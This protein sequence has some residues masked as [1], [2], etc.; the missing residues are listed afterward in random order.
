MVERVTRGQFLATTSGVIA[1]ILI[2]GPAYAGDMAVGLELKPEVVLLKQGDLRFPVSLVCPKFTVDGTEV[3]GKGPPVGK[4]GRMESGQVLEFPC[5]PIVLGD[6]SR[7][8]VKLCVEWSAYELVLRKW[9]AYRLDGASV[10]KL[11]SEVV[12]EDLNTKAAGPRLLPEQPVN[13]DGIQSRPVFLE[14]FFAGIEYPVA[15]CRAE[16]GRVIL[17]HRPGLRMQPG[18]WYQ[19]RKAVYGITPAGGEK[20]GFKR[21]IEAHRPMPKGS[22]HFMYNPYWS[23]PTTPSQ[24]QILEIMGI[25]SEKLYK[26]YGVAFDSCG[27][28]VFTTDTKSIW[29]VDRKRFPR[30]LADLQQACS[31]IGSHLDIFLSPCSGYPPALDPE[32][33]KEQ[34]YETCDRGAMRTLCLAGKRYQSQTKKAIVDT[35]VRYN[36]NHVFLDGYTFDCPASDHGHEPGALSMEPVADGLIDILTALRKAAPDVWLAATCFTWNASPWWCFHVNS[37]IGAY[38]DDAPYGRV[39]SPVYRESYT[40]ARDHFNLQGAYWL[41]APIAATESFGIIHQSDYPFLNDAVTDILRGNMEQHC[42]I[43][44]AYMSDIRW[45]Q[46]ASLMKWARRNVGILRNTEPLLPVSW[47]NGKCPQVTNDA[48][49]PREP[50]GYAHWG[51][52]RSLLVLRNPWIEPQTY[53]VKLP[54]DPDQASETARFSAVS[55]YPESRVYGKDLKPG[56][57]LDVRLAPYETVVLSF[58]KG[59]AP[60]DRPPVSQAICRQLNVKVL[61]SEVSLEKFAGNVDVLGGDSTCLVGNAEAGMRVDLDAEVNADAPESDVLIL[62]EEKEAP[63]DPICQLRVNGKEVPLSSGGSETGWA[64][65]MLPKPER[66]LFLSSPLPEGKSLISLNLLTRGGNPVVSAW[67]WAKK[68]GAVGGADY[69]NALPQ[70]EVISLDGVNLLKPLDA[71]A[72]SKITKT[73]ARPVERIDGVFLDAMDPSRVRATSGGLGKNACLSQAPIVIAGRRYLRGLGVNAP[74]RIAVSLDGNYRRFQ[75]WVGLDTAVVANYMDRSAVTFEVWVDG[76][77]RW[78]SGVVRDTDPAEP[79]KL[80]DIDVAGAKV[81]ELAVVAQEPHG[82]LAQNLVDWAEA[83]LLK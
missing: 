46:L 63:V 14:G 57:T 40:S 38:G 79:V 3:G 35:V 20:K 50:Y 1:T 51:D 47:Q 74:S 6:S 48:R 10:P 4:V 54:V 21:Y 66:W 25:L 71:K 15:Q 16:N 32:W 83:R 19:T 36:A 68:A 9:A 39:P 33:A 45:S 82:H 23:T 52:D 44:P 59:K 11:L 80:V 26:P 55:I 7:L 31:S 72:A 13:A 69:P 64:A 30:G 77:K 24:D 41:T 34:G 49:M 27:L 58:D 29:E 60:S 17:S 61:K 62:L 53:T 56:D 81:L 65:S 18:T 12:L 37:V 76:H 8:E 28:T 2:L 22:H 75:S 67:V 73:A 43:N 5:A 78:D 42:A 70:P